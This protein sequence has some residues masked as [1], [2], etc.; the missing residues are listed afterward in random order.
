MHFGR[1][2]GFTMYINNKYIQFDG[3]IKKQL[4]CQSNSLFGN[5]DKI[6]K[7]II[8]AASGLGPNLLM[9]LMGAFFTDAVNPSALDLASN[10]NKAVQTIAGT[11]LIVPWLFPILWFLAKSFDGFI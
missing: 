10:A 3:W 7:E 11:C 2:C 4:I 8:F 5:L 9:V 1:N 6:W